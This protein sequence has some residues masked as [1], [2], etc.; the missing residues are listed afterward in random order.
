[1]YSEKVKNKMK[2]GLYVISTPIGNLKDIT[3][4]A[5]DVLSHSDF[6]ICEDTRVSQKLLSFYNLQSNL[7]SNYKFNE[8][9]NLNKITNLL[10]EKKIISLISDAGTPTISDPGRILINECI[11]KNINIIP[12]PG[13]SAVTAS[14][15][16]SGFS[17][18]YYFHGFLPEKRNKIIQ[19]FEYLS[20]INNSIVFFISS[21]KIKKISDLIK[22]Y[23]S[24]RNLV[25]CR[26]ITKYYEEFLRCS[27]NDFS[28][29]KLSLKGEI[30][31]VISE[32]YKTSR[33]KIDESDKKNIKKM[34]HKFSIKDIIS[35]ISD[36]KNVSKNEIYKYC[37]NLKKNE[38]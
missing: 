37:L 10:N 27:V 26:E 11:K 6:I 36:K 34:I 8:V 35:I 4:R 15:S 22:K 3:L 5:L 7:L 29:F 21:K 19:D 17:D 12:I 32:K 2:S 14:V 23:F 16:I 18:Q 28:D 31:V 38:N 1:M 9:K 13:P 20:N 24:D 25:I 30:T 33:P